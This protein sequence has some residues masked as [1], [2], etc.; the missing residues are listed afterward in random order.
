LDD[1]VLLQFYVRI[2]VPLNNEIHDLILKE[3]HRE[4]YMAHQRVKR[5]NFDLEMLFFWKGMKKNMV[6][7][8]PR[9]LECQQVKVEHLH[10][11]G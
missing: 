5:M 8:V 4:I 10:L 9:C 2:Y 6:N 7:V 1:D 3:A 11:G